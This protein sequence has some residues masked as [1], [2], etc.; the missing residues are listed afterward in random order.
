M[1]KLSIL[2]RQQAHFRLCRSERETGTAFVGS[3]R[4][5]APMPP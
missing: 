5:F 2:P 3:N 4:E 1:P